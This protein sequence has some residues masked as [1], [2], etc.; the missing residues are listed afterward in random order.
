MLNGDQTFPQ[1]T[2]INRQFY[3]ILPSLSVRYKLGM[4]RNLRLNYRTSN[5]AP[6]VDQLQEVINNSNSLQL[7]VGNKSLV[8]DYQHNLT[9]RYFSVIPEKGK[10][11]FLLVNATYTKNYISSL[12]QLA[13]N[14]PLFVK[15]GDTGVLRLNPGAQLSKAVNL[16]GYYN[17]RLFGTYG[18]P[19]D[20]GKL[21]LNVNGGLNYVQ[22]PSLIQIGNSEAKAN[23][24]RNPSASLGIVLGTNVNKLDITL[25]STTTYS[26]V[27][28][29]LQ[30][31]LN[32]SYINQSTQ[33]KL[34]YN[35]TE[36]WAI[37][38]DV[39][40]SAFTGLSSSYNQTFYLWNMG[41][42]K[43]F[44]KNTI[45]VR[46]SVYDILNQNKAI[47]RNVTQT[48]FEDVNTR[49][50]TR[51]AMLTLTY[52][53]RQFKG[54]KDQGKDEKDRRMYMFPSGTPP[55]GIPMPGMGIPHGGG[56]N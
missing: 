41:L 26:Y 9:M 13:G 40:Q 53:L 47:S 55:S 16:D 11:L 46:L 56:L 14:G 52:N 12:T 8:Q 28:N 54:S 50:L 29:T 17:L 37:V 22:T 24:S 5:N 21:N 49:V 32:Q 31:S 33:F 4:K 6:S 43:K 7:S 39:T 42:A 34:N 51:Y 2:T 25:M 36:K 38:S 3:S 30:K 45:E 44:N 27:L 48:Y 23:T 1:I 15:V 18:T 19:L 35:P 10:N 20:S